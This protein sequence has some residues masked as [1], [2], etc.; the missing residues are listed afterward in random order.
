MKQV[1]TA[2]ML[3][4]CMITAQAQKQIGKDDLKDGDLLFC[5]TLPSD[6]VQSFSNAI[7]AVTTGIDGISIDHVAI[8][9]MTDSTQ[10]AIEAVPRHGVRE[11]AL[12]SLISAAR[13]EGNL[14]LAARVND[15]Y[16][17]VNACSKALTYLGREYDVLFGTSDEKIYCSELV[18]LSYTREDGEK[19]FE[20]AP[21]SFSGRDGKILP[22][23]KQYYAR[24][25]EEVPEG[26]AGTNPAAMSRS[27]SITIIGQLNYNYK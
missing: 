2:L 15:E 10:T 8:V 9:H 13:A 11:T 4:L 14:L 17:R 16:A 27:E 3:T 26:V 5:V 22:Y 7:T 21:M 23:W 25:G 24:Y 12:D 20:G 18:Q 6:D 19:V 1:V